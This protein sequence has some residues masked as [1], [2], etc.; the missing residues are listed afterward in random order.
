M[1]ITV[2][3]IPFAQSQLVFGRWDPSQQFLQITWESNGPAKTSRDDPDNCS[4]NY[5]KP[6]ME[7]KKTN[8]GRGRKW[9][10]S[11]S[12]DWGNKSITI[13][14]RVLSLPLSLAHNMKWCSRNILS[15]LSHSMNWLSPI[16]VGTASW[17][18]HFW[19]FQYWKLGRGRK[20]S[21]TNG[22]IA[23]PIRLVKRYLSHLLKLNFKLECILV[24]QGTL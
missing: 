7:Q 4:K 23:Y 19:S 1:E 3:G 15:S 6:Q 13:W 10:G 24:K 12:E 20:P 14:S 18:F 17:Y 9:S 21:A 22:R 8:R 16:W 2:G 11:S 5:C